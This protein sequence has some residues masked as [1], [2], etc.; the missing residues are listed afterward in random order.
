MEFEHPSSGP[1]TP[2]AP[3]SKEDKTSPAAKKPLSSP[4][5]GKMKASISRSQSMLTE[6]DLE[7]DSDDSAEGGSVKMM[8]RPIRLYKQR[9]D[10]LL[11]HQRRQPLYLHPAMMG[12]DGDDTEG[13]RHHHHHSMENFAHMIPSS[14]GSKSLV[15][16]LR[17][18]NRHHHP[19]RHKE[20][21]QQQQQHSASFLLNS[22]KSLCQNYR[23]GFPKEVEELCQ[24]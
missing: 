20:Q 1:E 4:R 12:E 13:Q 19:L 6:E 8:M 23:I 10:E 11:L 5:V 16:P 2:Q 3:N 15:S 21:Q 18:Q 9:Q 22:R 7:T 17:H 24:N 14:P